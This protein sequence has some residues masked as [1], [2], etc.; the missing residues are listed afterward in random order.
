VCVFVCVCVF[1][2]GVFRTPK[3]TLHGEKG[4]SWGERREA[5]AYTEQLW[6]L[7]AQLAHHTP[8]G[9][10]SPLLL[11]SYAWGGATPL[12]LSL[13]LTRRLSPPLSGSV[14]ICD[15]LLFFYPLFRDGNPMVEHAW[16]FCLGCYASISILLL[17]DVTCRRT[18]PVALEVIIVTAYESVVL[19]H[20]A[21]QSTAILFQH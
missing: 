10:A 2:G 14:L 13:M 20:T 3:T 17:W 16:P 6:S 21:R 11:P 4:G 7:S 12:L 8:G 18:G 5:S 15:R 19:V 9:G 1:S